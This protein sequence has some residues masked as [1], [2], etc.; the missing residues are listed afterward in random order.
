MDIALDYV[1]VLI[2]VGIDLMTEPEFLAEIKEEFAHVNE[3][4]GM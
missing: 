3:T 2:A 1:K 4:K